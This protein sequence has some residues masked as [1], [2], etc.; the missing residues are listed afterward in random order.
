MAVQKMGALL[1]IGDA[2]DADS[3]EAAWANGALDDCKLVVSSLGGTPADPTVDE[4][5]CPHPSPT[6]DNTTTE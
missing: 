4:V 6:D 2:L 3:V 5:S 1:H